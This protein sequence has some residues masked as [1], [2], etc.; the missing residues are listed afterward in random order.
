MLNEILA[1]HTGQS[2][3]KIKQDTERDFYMS[4]QEALEYGVIDNILNKRTG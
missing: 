4:P 3:D 2:K 1:Q